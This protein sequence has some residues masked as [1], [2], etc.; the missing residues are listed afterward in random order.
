MRRRIRKDHRRF[1]RIIKGRIR[2]DLQELISRGSLVG[3]QGGE[4]VKIPVKDIDIPEFRYDPNSAG[5]I[6]SGD[7][8]VGQPI[9]PG[10]T[11][12]E[13]QP[14]TGPGRHFREVEIELE[15]L[16]E[17]L[18]EE[19]ELPRIEPKG[20]RTSL[21]ESNAYKDRTVTGP[22]TLL[23]KKRAYKKGLLRKALMKSPDSGDPGK[24][25]E[26][27]PVPP[28]GRFSVTPVK[29]DKE[30]LYPE[31]REE[32]EVKAVIF[33]MRD[34]SGSMS[35]EKTEIIRQE[36]Y[37]IDVW[38]QANYPELERVYLVHDVDAKRVSEEDFYRLS[39]SGGTRISSVYELA[40]EL[41]GEDYPASEWNIY[42]FHFSD[43]ENFRA[44]TKEVCLPLLRTRLL[45]KVNLFGYG[46]VSPGEDELKKHLSILGNELDAERFVGSVIADG[47][48]VVGSIKTFLGEKEGG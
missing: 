30:Y 16:A 42:N 15:E 6:G 28:R 37:L 23:I 25:V 10:Q 38:L 22:E 18:G 12:P 41:I 27:V 35:G 46:Q 5:G 4:T 32:S 11:G 36:N 3:K 8:E 34:I 44:D 26:P 39:T 19:L 20:G 33:F 29:E 2:D 43:G 24:E 13:A 47:D 45:P 1:K 48:S 17:I 21:E 14:G 9:K 40:S 31:E 7:G